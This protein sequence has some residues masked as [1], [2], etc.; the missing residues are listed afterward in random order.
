MRWYYAHYVPSGPCAAVNY[1]MRRMKKA[2]VKSIALRRSSR[3]V[4]TSDTFCY[5]NEWIIDYFDGVHSELNSK[6]GSPELSGRRN[7]TGPFFNHQLVC[8]FIGTTDNVPA[9][10]VAPWAVNSGEW[11][12]SNTYLP[13]QAALRVYCC[14]LTDRCSQ[15]DEF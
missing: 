14:G 10:Q 1:Q 2:S 6:V 12:Q 7:G 5:R 11:S 9:V 3:N 13:R 8:L 15:R 4:Y